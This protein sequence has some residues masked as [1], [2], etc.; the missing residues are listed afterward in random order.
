[1][2]IQIMVSY[3][4]WMLVVIKFLDYYNNSKYK[5]V[6]MEKCQDGKTSECKNIRI[7]KC[8]W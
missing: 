7:V 4:F 3:T 6:R 5:N 2:L 1:M 8:Y